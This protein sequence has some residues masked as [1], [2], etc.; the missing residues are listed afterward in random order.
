MGE[1]KIQSTNIDRRHFLLGAAGIGA[2]L[3]FTGC[4]PKSASTASASS[5]STSATVQKADETV[6][7]GFVV[8]GSGM[9]GHCAAI[10]AA[11]SG[12][13]NV[14][15]LEGQSEVGGATKFAEG[16][17][18]VGDRYQAAQGYGGYDLSEILAEEVDWS[19]GVI[20]QSLF[21]AAMK[22]S[23][24]GIDWLLDLGVKFSAM[25]S[26]G[27]QRYVMHMYEGGNGT[28]AIEA[29]N[30]KA[31]ELGIDVRTGTSA[32]ALIVENDAVVG[33]Q[34]KSG[35]KIIEF[36]A[37]TVCIA[38]GAIAG[39][40]TMMDEYTKM[41]AGK[42]TYLGPQGQNGDG[43]TLVEAT[44]HGRAKN[45]CAQNMWLKV[46]DAGIKTVENYVA[47]MEGSN[48][49]VNEQGVRFT[50]EAV[51]Q[52]FFVANNIVGNQGSAYSLLDTDHAK[53]FEA[54][55]TT[56]FWSGFA[57]AMQPIEG[58]VDALDKAA[59][60]G[61]EKVFKANT[62]EELAGKIGVD[63]AT[64]KATVD[65]WNAQVDA[66]AD[67]EF[68]KPAPYCAK[69][70]TAPFYAAKLQSAVLATVG[71]IRVNKDGQVC[72]PLGKAIDGLYSAGVCS[73]GI[74]GEVYGMAA[75]G[76]TQ[77]SAVYLGR[78]AGKA[79]AQRA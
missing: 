17:F 47:G 65:A 63:A 18:G 75:P 21:M 22:D 76:I 50:N 69:V 55:G 36:R 59:A 56:C 45:I 67:T 48:I 26:A 30:P 2:A 35:N 77:Q 33:V 71:G 46:E 27:T 14:V 9:G 28:S 61:T 40:A 1:S 62:I 34:A 57:P 72:S 43:V 3:A 51:A 4:A 66:G 7:A 8:I 19:H 58:V 60:G 70:A 23:G 15:M 78:C 12:V 25:G 68:S 54:N 32:T 10:M 42:W 49:W 39:N 52:N 41:D 79:A 6:N 20:N 73:S 13:K 74:S 31:V 24:A 64:L 11:Q 29:L 5:Q 44:A 38:T 37:P 16:V 53:W